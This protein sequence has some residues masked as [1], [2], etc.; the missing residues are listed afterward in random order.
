M[1]QTAINAA[2]FLQFG[3][4]IKMQ[5]LTA[6]YPTSTSDPDPNPISIPIAIAINQVILQTLMDLCD[7]PITHF[8]R[9]M[10]TDFPYG[11][12]L[13]VVTLHLADM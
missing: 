4:A 6:G 13:Q 9:H 3:D 10:F 12:D 11:V 5:M 8:P 7:D 2:R 1:S